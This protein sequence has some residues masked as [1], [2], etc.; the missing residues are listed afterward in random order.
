MTVVRVGMMLTS[1]ERQGTGIM[2]KWLTRNVFAHFDTRSHDACDNMWNKGKIMNLSTVH[3]LR[4]IQ[5]GLLALVMGFALLCSA[6]IVPARPALAAAGTN[7]LFADER[8]Y[9]GQFLASANGQFRVYMQ[10]DGNL[11]LYDAVGVALWASLTHGKPGAWLINQ[12]DGNLVLYHNG[13]A[14][15]HSGTHGHGP[16]NLIMQDDGNLVLY[17]AGGVATWASGTARSGDRAALAARIRDS[18]RVTL[19]TYHVSGISDPA[20][21]ARQNIVDTANGLPAATSTYGHANGK[22]VDLDV[23]MLQGMLKLADGYSY[24]VTAIAGGKHSEGSRHYK[25]LAFDVDMINGARFSS[26]TATVAAFMQACRNAGATEVLG[27]GDAGHS[28]H[29]HC[30][31]PQ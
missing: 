27:P 22:R 17:K 13:V 31:W 6:A 26:R 4:S 29:I 20:S 2:N 25:G 12:G 3:R 16:S 18:G 19:L 15:W 28:T 23:R 21:T 5:H 24:R 30:A 11:V 8:L 1:E 7:T 9:P 14:V 10:D